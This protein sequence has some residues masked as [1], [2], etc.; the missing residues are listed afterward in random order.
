[1][2]LMHPFLFCMRLLL[3][4]KRE[5]NRSDFYLQ[6]AI[7]NARNVVYVTNQVYLSTTN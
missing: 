4:I 6:S 3:K 5:K 1:M 7:I 2:Q